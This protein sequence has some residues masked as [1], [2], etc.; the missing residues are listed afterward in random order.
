M[1][2]KQ[3]EIECFLLSL[4]A[5]Q[6]IIDEA[7][8]KGLQAMDDLARRCG[9]SD[10]LQNEAL[11]RKAHQDAV[12]AK[13]AKAAAALERKLRPLSAEERQRYR[14]AFDHFDADSSGELDQSEF[15]KAMIDSGMYPLQFEVK[16]LFEE[17][18]ADGS[19]KVDF[20]EYCRF[21]QVYKSKQVGP[22]SPAFESEFCF[23]PTHRP[24]AV[25]GRT[26]ARLPGGGCV[27]CWCSSV[28]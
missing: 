23:P 7:E 25:A 16:S 24:H 6:K 1:P 17:A 9:A 27:V 15:K 22:L 20:E 11:V 8:A 18:D 28:S 19:G 21:V 12:E 5:S 26:A 13:R 14:L 2:L 10:G 3:M 4:G